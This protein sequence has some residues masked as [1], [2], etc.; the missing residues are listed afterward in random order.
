[1]KE[2]FIKKLRHNLLKIY[3]PFKK[4]KDRAL[5][6][7]RFSLGFRISL[8]YA[9]LFIIYGI[10]ILLLF[11]ALFITIFLYEND[12]RIEEIKEEVVK[13]AGEDY[14]KS[15]YSQINAYRNDGLEIQ[16]K[17][18]STR[19]MIYSDTED[20]LNKDANYFDRLYLKRIGNMTQVFIFKRES[21]KVDYMSTK[22][23]LQLEF[24][25]DLSRDYNIYVKD[26]YIMLIAIVLFGMF[27]AYIG[28][29]QM[30]FIME[31]IKD[32]S[33]AA[34]KLNVNN[35]GSER[36][37]VNGTKNE[38]KDL[39]QTINDML[40]R[41]EIS[42]ESQ[43]QFVSNA[44]HELRT[45]IAVIQGYV[46]MVD[47]W[48]KEDSEIMEEAINA[49]KEESTNMKELVEK[50]LFLS[51]HDKKTLKL[52]KEIFNMKEIVDELV[53]ETIMVA[54]NRE[55]KNSYLDDV[56]VYGDKQ[57]LKQAIRV[58]VDNA[59][60]YSND[61]DCIN[62]S[63]KNDNGRCKVIVEDTGIG[64]KEKDI[65]NIFDRF[66]RSEDVRNKSIN[67]HGLGLSIAKLIILKHTGTIKVRSQY[68][69]GT[70]FIITLPK[71][72]R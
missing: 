58:F 24:R 6:K 44:S 36:L 10:I 7:L 42:Y 41:L 8:N 56:L 27:F 19:N 40:D 12:K 49:I 35:L 33:E 18:A 11:G 50:L 52:K 9:K 25:V 15:D 54:A 57:S 4:K 2:V 5:S 3:V 55:I 65:K 1:M 71:T 14:R 23:T 30:K 28:A 37:N 53:K 16:I 66:Y 51:R 17:E 67:G 72:Y 32:M 48:G 46:N 21:I 39:A 70:K 62:I 29:R 26:M 60:K 63:C 20:E 31:P 68:N 61:G 59:V 69:V 22:V 64:M 43:K 38:L 47:R 13:C 45:P 34:N